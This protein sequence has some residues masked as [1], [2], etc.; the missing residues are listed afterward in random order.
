MTIGM[1]VHEPRFMDYLERR[2][3]EERDQHHRHNAV[4]GGEAAAAATAAL[5]D[6]PCADHIQQL[7]ERIDRLEYRL[8][9]EMKR[10]V[11]DGILSYSAY[12]EMIQKIWS[13]IASISGEAEAI[14]MAM[15]Y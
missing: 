8:D 15:E 1:Q 14:D 4:Q 3:Q 9:E 7:A 12:C 11:A 6:D 13:H 2:E 5:D 10:A